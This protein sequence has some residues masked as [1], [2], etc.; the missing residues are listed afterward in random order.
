MVSETLVSG[1]EECVWGSGGDISEL[2]DSAGVN[3][4]DYLVICLLIVLGPCMQGVCFLSPLSLLLWRAHAPLE[5]AL[6]PWSF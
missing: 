5:V 2:R 6:G 3:S 4:A 1:R